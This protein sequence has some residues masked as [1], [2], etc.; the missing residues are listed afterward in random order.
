MST[1]RFLAIATLIQL[2]GTIGTVIA[3]LVG[4]DR[5]ISLLIIGGLALVTAIAF[6]VN[7]LLVLRR[8]VADLE[9]QMADLD[10][11][12][13]GNAEAINDQALFLTSLARREISRPEQQGVGPHA[14]ATMMAQKAA[15]DYL[16]A[17]RGLGNNL[18]LRHGPPPR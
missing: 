16:D 9:R 15:R 13:Q 14:L 12:G 11:S 8:R 7:Y 1:P 4:L 10:T 6:L 2:V 3:W 5:W 18:E 17:Y